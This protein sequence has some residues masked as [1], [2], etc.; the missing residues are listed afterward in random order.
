MARFTELEKQRQKLQV[1]LDA[2]KSQKERNV[3]GQFSTPIALASEILTH[4]KT[5]MPARRSIRF[6]DPAVG[7]GSFFSAL[8]S[9]FPTGR[10]ESATG[11]EIDSH[12][13]EP[14]REL[15]SGTT[16]EYHIDDFTLQTPPDADGGKYNL[17]I[18]NPPYVRHHHIKNR[19]KCL[20]ADAE[21]SANMKLSG[22]A[23]LYCYFLALAH[24]WMD[25]DA[26]AGWLVPS[27]FMDVNYGKSVKDYLLNEVTLLHIHRFD[28]KDVQFCD[29]LVSTAVVWF[30]KKVPKKTFKVLFSYGGTF[31]KPAKNKEVSSEVLASERKWSR[32]PLAE[33]RHN[34]DIPRIGDFFKVS[35]GIATG[36]NK[37]FIL[38]KAQIAERSLPLGQFRP[39][40]P[41]P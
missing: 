37:F 22:L 11:F 13:G 21:K 5:I 3:L 28:P 31:S 2:K 40:L 38:T 35:R 12:Y 32:F 39:I 10:I 1:M 27:E 14:S 29:A 17:I 20:Q 26:V 34:D 33:E 15:W 4:A 6:L 9:V 8:T 36:N 23:G 41:S 16:L 30:K 19:K 24:S 18:C 25:Q 7:T